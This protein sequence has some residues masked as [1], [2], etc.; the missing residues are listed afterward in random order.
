VHPGAGFWL[1]VGAACLALASVAA[2]LVA[3]GFERFGADLTRTRFEGPAA[4]VAAA[5][6]VL[7]LPAFLL[8]L[9]DSAGWA[10]TGTL[11]PTFGLSAFRLLAA[12]GV[13]LGALLLAPRCRSGQAAGLY[14]GVAVVLVLRLLRAVPG[15]GQL[16]AGALGTGGLGEGA[17]ASGLCLAL[18]LVALAVTMHTST[19]HALSSEDIDRDAGR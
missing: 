10:G 1:L 17:W 8:P 3:G 14:A 4:P 15:I 5:A 7:T 18:V 6:A 16:G 19:D 9:S 2:V 13:C 12:F 11:Q